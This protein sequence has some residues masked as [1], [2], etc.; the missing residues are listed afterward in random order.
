MITKMEIK[1]IVDALLHATRVGDSISLDTIGDAID[2]TSITADEIGEVLNAL[3]RAG[4]KI[5]HTP[6]TGVEDL[7]KVLVA[8]RELN[9]LL[10]RR[11]T[12]AEIALRAAIAPS[13][14]RTALALAQVMGR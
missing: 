5:S 13:R 10:G 8:A 4:R 12:V 2:T 7:R 9:A 6:S 3:E 14:V 11:P 1:A